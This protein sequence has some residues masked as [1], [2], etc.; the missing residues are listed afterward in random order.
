MTSRVA[1]QVPPWLIA[2][3]LLAAAVLWLVLGADGADEVRAVAPS[4]A[5]PP[6]AVALAARPIVNDTAMQ[7]RA[8]P[9]ARAADGACLG[10]PLQ[11]HQPE[12]AQTDEECLGAPVSDQNGDVRRHHF[13]AASGWALT[14]RV[15]AGSVLDVVASRGGEIVASCESAACTGIRFGLPDQDALQTIDLDTL[16]LLDAEGR[17]HEISARLRSAPGLGC[18]GQSV[19]LNYSDSRYQ[20]F[21]PFGGSG[22]VYDDAGY[23]SLSFRSLEGTAIIVRLDPQ[24]RVIGVEHGVHRCAGAACTGVLALLADPLGSRAIRFAGTVLNLPEG[25]DDAEAGAL[26][27]TLN[28]VLDL[29]PERPEPP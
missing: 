19:A 4:S 8:T 17:R 28:G 3:G 16:P 9:G 21:C 14:I 1:V 12:A 26:S 29:P 7:V 15:S 11:I 18:P 23:G 10:T 24:D 13:G 27:V 5:R 25:Q 22:V 20:H 2:A 6:A